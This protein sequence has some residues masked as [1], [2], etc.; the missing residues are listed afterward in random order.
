VQAYAFNKLGLLAFAVIVWMS[1]RETF[2]YFNNHKGIFKWL[3]LRR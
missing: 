1:A 3:N 2:T